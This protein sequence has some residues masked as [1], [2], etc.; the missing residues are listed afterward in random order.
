[1]Q[2]ALK[3][4]RE[5]Q[6]AIHKQLD[7]TVGTSQVSAPFDENI[8]KIRSELSSFEDSILRHCT[9]IVNSRN[10]H[11]YAPI[12][13]DDIKV[14][15]SIYLGHIG[16]YEF[17]VPGGRTISFSSEQSANDC[18]KQFAANRDEM[19]KF[20]K[21]IDGIEKEKFDTIKKQTDSKQEETM[22]LRKKEG[23]LMLDA[24]SLQD[25]L[26]EVQ[27]RAAQ[28]RVLGAPIT[29]QGRTTNEMPDGKIDWARVI[30]TNATRL[31][32]LATMFFW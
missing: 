22:P 5:Q 13:V 1:V 15:P 18:L 3:Q 9:N 4:N 32:A 31:G 14:A 16:E 10:V 26:K 2:A 28:E 19:P 20:F 21:R 11:D 30:E 29:P 17:T 8:S 25:L 23:Q 24:M 7:E 6:A 27:T 12:R